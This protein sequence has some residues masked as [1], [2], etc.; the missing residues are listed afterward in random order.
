MADTNRSSACGRLLRAAAALT[1]GLAVALDHIR[2]R[3][4]D[5]PDVAPV[6]WRCPMCDGSLADTPHVH[7]L[8]VFWATDEEGVILITDL[9]GGDTFVVGGAE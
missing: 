2:D 7:E 3:Y 5:Q 1:A 6:R 4:H 8:D 9:Q